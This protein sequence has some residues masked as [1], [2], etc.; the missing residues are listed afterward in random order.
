MSGGIEEED[1]A[2]FKT[3]T[4]CEDTGI[5]RRLLEVN[6]NFNAGIV[7]AAMDA[8][9]HTLLGWQTPLSVRSCL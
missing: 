5:A 2:S 1:L 9:L 8:T 4:G 6:S 3:F 7:D